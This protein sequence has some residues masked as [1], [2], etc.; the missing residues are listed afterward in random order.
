M[1]GYL[2]DTNIISEL[3]RNPDGA[4][5]PGIEAGGAKPIFTSIVVASELRYGC[6]KKGSPRLLSRVEELLAMIPV[7]PLDTPADAKYGGIPGRLEGAGQAMGWN[8]RRAR[9]RA[10]SHLGDG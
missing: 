6:A 9:L 5:A 2:L 8:D 10:E 7:L 3:I 4:V 1:S